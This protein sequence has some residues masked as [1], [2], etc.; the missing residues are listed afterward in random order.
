MVFGSARRPQGFTGGTYLD[1]SKGIIG[2]YQCETVED[3][4]T[5]AAKDSN[6]V[7]TFFVVEGTPYG[8]ELSD[9]KHVKKLGGGDSPQ[10][11]LADAMERMEETNRQIAEVAQRGLLPSGDKDE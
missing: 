2:V 1:W 11:R 5:A 8:V 7:G 10:D 3:A 4:F 9:T 6:D